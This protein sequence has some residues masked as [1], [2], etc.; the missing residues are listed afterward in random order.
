[1]EGLDPTLAEQ[2]TKHSS[3][4]FIGTASIVNVLFE[5][6]EP[7]AKKLIV[8]LKRCPVGQPGFRACPEL[9]LNLHTHAEALRA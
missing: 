8:G 1:M 7:A 3:V 9:S 4:A 6:S 2:A 5:Q